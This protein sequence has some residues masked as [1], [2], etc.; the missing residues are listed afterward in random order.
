M[1]YRKDDLIITY[2]PPPSS[3]TF[4]VK[5]ALCQLAF[6]SG[7]A[8]ISALFFPSSMLKR[9]TVS[10]ELDVDIGLSLEEHCPS[11]RLL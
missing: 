1:K 11:L 2:L 3:L 5:K 4:P 9:Q 7:T 8:P 10:L 6:L